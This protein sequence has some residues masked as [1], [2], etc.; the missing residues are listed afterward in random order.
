MGSRPVSDQP[1]ESIVEGFKDQ[2]VIV[3]GGSSGI[4]EAIVRAMYNQGARVF[5][6]GLTPVPRELG[7]RNGASA[8]QFITHKAQAHRDAVPSIGGTHPRHSPQFIECDVTKQND[9]QLEIVEH[10]NAI[11][12]EN[13]GIDIIIDSIGWS[14]RKPLEELTYEEMCSVASTNSHYLP[15]ALQSVKHWLKKGSGRVVVIG[16]TLPHGMTDTNAMAYGMAKASRLTAALALAS[17]FGEDG[18]NICVVSPSHVPT[19]NE[20]CILGAKAEVTS[21]KARASRPNGVELTTQDV[22]HC[23]LTVVASKTV[24][25]MLTGQEIMLGSTKGTPLQTMRLREALATTRNEVDA[26]LSMNLSVAQAMIDKITHLGEEK[27]A[28]KAEL[29]TKNT[30]LEKHGIDPETGAIR[31]HAALLKCRTTQ[32]PNA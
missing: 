19:D 9:R 4:G 25:D 13:N 1:Y 31:N 26:L 17:G 27:G 5:S 18:I 10:L 12:E 15:I 30:L 2:T 20:L 29:D 14:P 28:L 16:S 3:L 23:V 32:S 11:G 21:K 7:E 22:A 8:Q 24:S 6:L